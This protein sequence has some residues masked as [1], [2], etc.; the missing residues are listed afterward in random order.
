[1]TGCNKC[2]IKK[3]R[4]EPKKSKLSVVMSYIQMERGRTTSYEMEQVFTFK[5][6]LKCRETVI[7]NK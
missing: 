1:M 5:I 7:L 6:S 3:T 2:H 4:E